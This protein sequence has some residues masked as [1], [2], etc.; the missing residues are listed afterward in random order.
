MTKGDII[1]IPFDKSLAIGKLG[2]LQKGEIIELNKN[3]RVL[4][5]L[6]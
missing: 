1:L 4:F 6:N 5:Q 3:L 2:V